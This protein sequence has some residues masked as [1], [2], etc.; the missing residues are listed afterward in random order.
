[1]KFVHTH[2]VFQVKSRVAFHSEIT[3]IVAKIVL[4]KLEL[5]ESPLSPL[6]LSSGHPPGLRD[7]PA[8]GIKPWTSL[9]KSHCFTTEPPENQDNVLNTQIR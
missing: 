7:C 4:Q 5:Q 1:M 9:V 3:D 2:L 8:L 6:K